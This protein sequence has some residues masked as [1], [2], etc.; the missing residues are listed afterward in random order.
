[1]VSGKQCL[2]QPHNFIFVFML[3]NEFSVIS[4]WNGRAAHAFSRGNRPS[5][6]LFDRI[7]RLSAHKVRISRSNEEKRRRETSRPRSISSVFGRRLE[8]GP[9]AISLLRFESLMY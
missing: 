8:R 1:M 7:T 6:S 2:R 5:S 9:A 3:L 4:E